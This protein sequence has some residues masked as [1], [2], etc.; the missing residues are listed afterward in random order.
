MEDIATDCGRGRQLLPGST[1]LRL[2]WFLTA[3]MPDTGLP[4]PPC[5][6]AASKPRSDEAGSATSNI[7]LPVPD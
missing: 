1:S 3:S 7:H 4:R 6:R 5:P 2:P